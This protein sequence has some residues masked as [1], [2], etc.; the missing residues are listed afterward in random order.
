MYA[1][2]VLS[3]LGK[4]LALAAIIGLIVTVLQWM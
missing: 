3:T 1:Q 4:F 2:S